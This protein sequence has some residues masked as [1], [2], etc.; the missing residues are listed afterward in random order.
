M[1]CYQVHLII[2]AVEQDHNVEFEE[3]TTPQCISIMFLRRD[4]GDNI[5]RSFI[6]IL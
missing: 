2:V 3:Y 6:W 1:G 5:F 4:T